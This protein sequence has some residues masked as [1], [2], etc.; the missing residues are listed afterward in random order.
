MGFR[1]NLLHN[2]SQLYMY[3]TVSYRNHSLC[4]TACV[5]LFGKAPTAWW[6]LP[7]RT[8]ILL[9][10]TLAK[11]GTWD[12]HQALL[13]CWKWNPACSG[14][15]LAW[16]LVHVLELDI[17]GS[18]PR[19]SFSI[20]ESYRC[21]LLYNP[22]QVYIC[23]VRVRNHSVCACPVYVLYTTVFNSSNKKRSKKANV[24]K[25]NHEHYKHI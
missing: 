18:A 2:C 24:S 21:N 22:Y 20:M 15:A 3:N 16:N 17:F 23:T 4:V 9:T 1:C 7:S 13:R 8:H 25:K 11:K 19:F 10:S 5:C 14:S 12:E 6:F